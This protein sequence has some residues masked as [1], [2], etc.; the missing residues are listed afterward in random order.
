MDRYIDKYGKELERALYNWY[1]GGRDASPMPVFNVLAEGIE[2]DMQVFVPIEIPM[3]FYEMMGNNEDVKVG[4]ILLIQKDIRIGFK[5]MPSQKEGYYYIPIFTNE[6]AGRRFENSSIINQSLNDL[7]N[8]LKNTDKCLGYMINPGN[9]QLAL[10]DDTI[11]MI[12]N[13][14]R[15]SQIVPVKG[16]VVDMHVDA[17]VNAAKNSLLG[18]GGVDGAIHKAAGKELLKECISLRGCNTGDAKITK[19]YNIKH[20]DYI[21]H[22]VG[23]RYRGMEE[24]A[25]L[26]GS[27]Y[28]RCLDIALENG[29]SDIAFPCISTGAYGYPVHK[30]ASVAL[31]TIAKWMDTHED[32]VMNVYICC[33]LDTEMQAYRDILGIE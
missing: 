28:K 18:G 7:I 9:M 12:F 5:H 27:C 31:S 25:K 4:D 33:F 16:S 32:I 23:P 11:S 22:T 10:N 13:H 3:E 15:E 20:A 30:A 14:R 24:D 8:A 6:E 17:I 2:N 26:L 19:A 21:I 1:Y 29:C